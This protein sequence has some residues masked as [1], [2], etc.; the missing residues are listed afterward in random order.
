MLT[1]TLLSRDTAGLVGYLVMHWLLGSLG[2]S[3]GWFWKGFASYQR[4]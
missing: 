2:F 3:C 4:L 1:P